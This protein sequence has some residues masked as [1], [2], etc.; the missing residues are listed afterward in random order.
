[1]IFFPNRLPAKTLE[2]QK[3]WEKKKW[4]RRQKSTR[5]F[6]DIPEQFRSHLGIYQ[7]KPSARTFQEHDWNL[8]GSLEDLCTRE[9]KKESEQTRLSFYKRKEQPQPYV[10]AVF[11]PDFGLCDYRS[12][13][14]PLSMLVFNLEANSLNYEDIPVWFVSW[15]LICCSSV[16]MNLFC[17][18]C[19][20]KKSARTWK[21]CFIQVPSNSNSYNQHGSN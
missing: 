19:F 14:S 1:M 11:Q 4:W 6:W 16:K 15:C 17:F 21:S 3:S 5:R 10:E 18:V 7:E 12:F 8:S 2:G 13:T 9:D 20:R